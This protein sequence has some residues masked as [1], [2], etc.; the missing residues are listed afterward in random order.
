M[1]AAAD[2]LRAMVFADAVKAQH[3]RLS[4][5]QLCVSCEQVSVL[6]GRCPACGDRGSLATLAKFLS[7]AQAPGLSGAVTEHAP[8]PGPR[9]AF[10]G[11]EMNG[12]HG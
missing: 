7:P 5:L 10:H 6:S 2:S 4:D 9:G 8:E 3:W 12:L 11:G 1:S